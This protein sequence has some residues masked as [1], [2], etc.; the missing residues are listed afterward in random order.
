MELCMELRKGLGLAVMLLA[1]HGCSTELSEPEVIKKVNSYID[2][3]QYKEAVITLKDFIKSNPEANEIRILAGNV[4]LDSGDYWSAEKEFTRAFENGSSEARL[5][6]KISQ[7]LFYKGDTDGLLELSTESLSPEGKATVLTYQGLALAFRQDYAGAD[8][9]LEDALKYN[10]D[11]DLVLATIAKVDVLRGDHAKARE[12]VDQTLK[13]SPQCQ[14][15][16]SV[17]G[18]LEFAQREYAKAVEDYSKAIEHGS[19]FS[20]DYFKRAISYIYL[21]QPDQA[22]ADL[23]RLNKLFGA[24]A[25]TEFAYGLIQFNQK[26]YQEAST[27]FDKSLKLRSDYPLALFYMAVAQNALENYERAELFAQKVIA[28]DKNNESANTL[29]ATILDKRGRHSEAADYLSQQYR[30]TPQSMVYYTNLLVRAGRTG[31]AIAVMNEVAELYPDS[32]EVQAKLG[33]LMLNMGDQAGIEKL[34]TALALDADYYYADSALAIN[35]LRNREFAQT[36]EA[37]ERIKVSHPELSLPYGIAGRAYLAMGEEKKAQAEF[38]AGC[39][40][41]AGDTDTCLSYGALLAEQGELEKA[42]AVYRQVINTHPHLPQGYV[43]LSAIHASEDNFKQFVEVLEQGIENTDDLMPRLVLA[44]YYLASNQVSKVFPLFQGVAPG[45][46]SIGMFDVLAKA[47]IQAQNFQVA[48]FNLNNLLALD[49]NSAEAWYLMSITEA[50]LKQPRRAES[51]LQRSLQVDSNYYPARLAM[52]K[53]EIAKRDLQNAKQHYQNLID[54]N[55]V[56]EEILKVKAGIEELSGDNVAALETYQK[57]FS[58]HPSQLNMLLLSQQY[59]NVGDKAAALKLRQSWAEEHT[60]NVQAQMALADVYISMEEQSKAIQQ[61]KRVVELNP[62]HFVALNNLAWLLK[63][64]SPKEALQYS[65]QAY[66]INPDSLDVLDTLALVLGK[67]GDYN[68]AKRTIDRVVDRAPDNL[69]FKYHRALIDAD[70]GHKESAKRILASL[71]G[72][73]FPEKGAATDLLLSLIH[74]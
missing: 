33:S 47:N 20:Q 70:A 6:P 27:Y 63:D 53:T 50:G 34:E 26:E 9:R 1:I 57:I 8:A 46:D 38:Q 13:A 64:S 51:S 67:N 68:R 32:A 28:R 55:P 14:Y 35:H 23:S 54:N 39:E 2:N 61:Y 19:S 40:L 48:K 74:I 59:W 36:L 15:C 21:D 72:S 25:E 11:S 5:L 24:S 41:T 45:A 37:A 43:S 49:K 7:T 17:L 12:L 66:H 71:E 4:Y 29:M 62:K 56:S 30:N 60:D 52:A 73:D 22:Q 42:Q 16:W 18:D 58:D 69:T 3:D 44:R 10:A 65:E 31:E